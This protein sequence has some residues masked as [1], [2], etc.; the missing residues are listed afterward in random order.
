MIIE[1]KMFCYNIKVESVL[2][3]TNL[4]LNI[5]HRRQFLVFLILALIQNAVS[6]LKRQETLLKGL[7]LF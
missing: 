5:Y 1:S 2:N 7:L 3:Q 6:S 4:H